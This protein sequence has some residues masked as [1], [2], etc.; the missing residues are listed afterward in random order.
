MNVAHDH[1]PFMD[2]LIQ[3][4]LLGTKYQ[5]VNAWVSR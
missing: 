1:R 5:R 2:D 3:R 4:L